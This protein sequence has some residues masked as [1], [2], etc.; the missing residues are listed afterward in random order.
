MK[1]NAVEFKNGGWMIYN[2]NGILMGTGS[3][4]DKLYRL[5]VESVA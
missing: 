5:K 2:K 3:L 4:V 1:G